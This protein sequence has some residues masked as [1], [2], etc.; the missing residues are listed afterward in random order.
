MG[1]VAGTPRA[2]RLSE[3]VETL[4]AAASGAI[5]AEVAEV[6]Q[7][8]PRGRSDLVRRFE[9][10]RMGLKGELEV[11]VLM[12]WLVVAGGDRM[13][14]DP[15]KVIGDRSNRGTASLFDDL[16][17]CGL[18]GPGIARVDMSARLKPTQEPTVLDKED[19]SAV[20]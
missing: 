2:T 8:N 17:H 7:S 10:V 18:E 9:M 6:G 12:R 5:H 20:R 13:D 16:T 3:L 4:G 19:R 15:Q 11:V 1:G 14:V